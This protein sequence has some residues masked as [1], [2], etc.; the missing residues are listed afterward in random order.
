MD[1]IKFE[2]MMLVKEDLADM[3]EGLAS[4]KSQIV[5]QPLR[6]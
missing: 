2:L 6:D 1:Y 4:N 3:P 5:I